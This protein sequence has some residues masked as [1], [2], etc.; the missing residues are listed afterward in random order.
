MPF[1]LTLFN[2]TRLSAC[3]CR[4]HPDLAVVNQRLSTIIRLHYIHCRE[5]LVDRQHI[6]DRV[7]DFT[8][9]KALIS[10]KLLYLTHVLHDHCGA[11]AGRLLFDQLESKY[12]ESMI[13][14]DGEGKA[15]CVPQ[16]RHWLKRWVCPSAVSLRLGIA[17]NLRLIF[18]QPSH[19]C[20]N[21]TTHAYIPGE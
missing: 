16:L 21:C 13:L 17:G 20:L 3:V 19:D 12:A 6:S 2:R 1:C 15:T 5:W 10:N 9:V 18:R 4:S 8:V 14:A 7:Q 11:G